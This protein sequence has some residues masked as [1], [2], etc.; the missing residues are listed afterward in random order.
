MGA[1]PARTL[2]RCIWFPP[3]VCGVRGFP[4]NGHGGPVTPPFRL[5]KDRACRRELALRAARK[6]FVRTLDD[7]ARGDCSSS[8]S[9]SASTSLCAHARVVAG[10]APAAERDQPAAGAWKRPARSDESS[11]F[12]P[13][14]TQPSPFASTPATR[15]SPARSG[16]CNRSGERPDRR[17]RPRASCRW[18]R[19][20]RV[21][22]ASATAR[23]IT[24]ARSAVCAKTGRKL[25][26]IGWRCRRLE[27]MIPARPVGHP[28]RRLRQPGRTGDVLDDRAELATNSPE[29]SRSCSLSCSGQ[30]SSQRCPAS[31]DVGLSLL[32]ALF[33]LIAG[34]AWIAPLKP[35]A[36]LDRKRDS[37]AARS[38]RSVIE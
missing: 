8:S 2:V 13:S 37:S 33:Y 36:A 22:P 15:R 21:A 1:V 6:A 32:Q 7:G 29:S 10:Y 5:V 18:S 19:S 30:R 14:P 11:P 26:G 25:I 27:T 17:S 31:S 16:S 38:G 9:P 23:A 4:A 12:P 24:T 35:L 3:D 34:I 20:T 28:A